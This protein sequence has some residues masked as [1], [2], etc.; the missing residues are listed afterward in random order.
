M[1]KKSARILAL[2]LALTSALALTGCGTEAGAVMHSG[3][4]NPQQLLVAEH[5]KE[6]LTRICAEMHRVHKETFGRDDDLYIGLQLT[7]SG[8]YSHPNRADVLESK[9]AYSHPLLDR[10][11][12]NGPQNVVTDEEVGDIIQHFIQAARIAGR[13]LAAALG[14]AAATDLSCRIVPNGCVAAIAWF[15]LQTY[16]GSLALGAGK[17]RTIFKVVLPSAMPGIIAAVIL[18][19]GRVV[20]ESA[21]F[22][23]TMGAS[24]KP[25]P[26]GYMSSGTTLAVA[27]YKL[28]SE[29]LHTNEAYATACILIVIV[30]AL[31]LLAEW[32]G[33]KLEKK[34]NGETNGI[35]TK[36]KR[37]AS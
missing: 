33:K 24:I 26:D 20:S 9:T 5:T 36:H 17:L 14:V 13:V 4:S 29:N 12:H 15:G 31:N 28:S 8:R 30:L 1:K 25:M 34:L 2:T 16:T 11:F 19:I 21:P 18:S 7:H 37:K 32:V 10:K 6:A 23:F 35:R 27:L 3:R 22:M